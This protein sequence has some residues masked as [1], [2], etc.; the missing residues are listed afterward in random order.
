MATI[1]DERYGVIRRD[2]C[3]WSL[4]YTVIFLLQPSAFSIPSLPQPIPGHAADAQPLFA[5]LSYFTLITLSTVGYRDITPLSLQA[6]LAAAAE[7]IT[8]QFYRG[9]PIHLCGA[10]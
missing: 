6:R 5:I 9:L 3:T 7:G 8:G 10:S 1:N 4:L 2:D